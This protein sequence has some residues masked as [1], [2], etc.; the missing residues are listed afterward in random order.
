MFDPF[1]F[2][3]SPRRPGPRFLAKVRSAWF[4]VV[5]TASFFG[6]VLA[7][8]GRILLG[9]WPEPAGTDFL[10]PRGHHRAPDLTSRKAPHPHR[11]FAADVIHGGSS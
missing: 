10:T 1:V 6:A 4:G 2:S 5:E 11:A 3:K 8:V 7:A 9:R